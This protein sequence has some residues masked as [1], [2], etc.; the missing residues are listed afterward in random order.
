[1]A[2]ARNW[3]FT[4]NNYKV[5]ELETIKQFKYSY[6]IIGDEKGEN[7]T[8][9]LQG[10]IE[11]VDTH[12]LSSLKKFIPRAHL[13]ISKGNGEQNKEYCSKE[14]VLF[15]NGEIKRQGKRSDIQSVRDHVEDGANMRAIVSLARSLQSIRMAEIYLTYN[16]SKRNWKPIVKW[17]YGETGS[18]KSHTAYEESPDAYTCGETSKWFQGYDGHENVIID[19]F[20]RDFIKFHEL[21]KLLDKYP[22]LIEY[23]GGSR[24]F[25]AKQII[26]TSPYHPKD[27]YENRED[28]DQLIR[29]IDEIKL[30]EKIPK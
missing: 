27:V 18:G 23:K 10:Y 4:L 28:I 26:I 9:H 17:Y 30:F 6:M 2:R 14:R 13:E 22:Y 12:T 1:M 24:Q 25:L 11:F 20:R 3:S 29:R 16:E 7:E 15:E 19:D 5:E 21:L 8:P